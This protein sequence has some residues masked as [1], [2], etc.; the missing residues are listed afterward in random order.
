[1][2]LSVYIRFDWDGVEVGLRIA[3]VG[4]SH[5][6]IEASEGLITVMIDVR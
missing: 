5:V 1:M 6:V 2:V 4:S 3:T